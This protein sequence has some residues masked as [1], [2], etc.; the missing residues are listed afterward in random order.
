MNYKTIDEF[1]NYWENKLIELFRVIKR[2]DDRIHFEYKKGD[3]FYDIVDSLLNC[4]MDGMDFET[5]FAIRRDWIDDL[6]AIK[7]RKNKLKGEPEYILA[8]EIITSYNFIIYDLNE[9]VGY[10]YKKYIAPYLEE[11]DSACFAFK[12]Y[13]KWEKAFCRKISKIGTSENYDIN[14]MVNKINELIVENGKLKTTIKTII[15]KS[16]ANIWDL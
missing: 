12:K 16:E 14:V 3:S 8:L 1:N 4:E 11:Y 2:E 5:Q 13:L 9:G 6:H 7:N 10:L 15:N